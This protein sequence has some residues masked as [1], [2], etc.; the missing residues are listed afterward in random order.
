VLV[1]QSLEPERREQ[2]R[3][4]IPDAFRSNYRGKPA[5]QIGVFQAR[6]KVEEITQLMQTNGFD[7]IVETLP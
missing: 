7:T 6:E 1:T 3:Q 4:L 5:L 2:L